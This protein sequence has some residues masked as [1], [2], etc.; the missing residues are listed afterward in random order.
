MTWDV[1]Q[2]ILIG[3]A[4]ITF[5]VGFHA[6]ALDT[7]I[8]TIRPIESP[9][10]TYLPRFWR[11]VVVSIVVLKVFIAHLIEI[12]FWALLYL[13]LDI[14]ALSDL[15]SALYYSTSSFTTVGFGDLVLDVDWR[16]LGSFESACG[17]IL[18][19]LSAAFI[20]E[21]IAPLYRVDKRNIMFSAD[22]D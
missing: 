8:K 10:K 13:W 17:F 1:L 2:Q 20:F 9:I 4:M 12:F 22:Q 15:E 6:F 11:A 3:L 18:F 7:I 14:P 16:L 5:T 21:I 19:G